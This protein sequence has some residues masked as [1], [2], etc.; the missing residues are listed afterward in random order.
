MLESHL[1]T[2]VEQ[3]H[4]DLEHGL[5]SPIAP[6]TMGRQRIA[7]ILPER[8]FAG[9]RQFPSPELV[10]DFAQFSILCWDDLACL[11][12]GQIS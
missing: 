1:T 4:Q 12:L 9:R 2:P 11:D 5:A 10:K 8:D 3:A 7:V 6:E